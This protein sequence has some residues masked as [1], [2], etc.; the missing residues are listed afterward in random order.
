MDIIKNK[1][2]QASS[3]LKE[4]DIDCWIIYL[5]ESSMSPDPAMHMVIGHEVTWR[6]LFVYT[7]SGKAYALVG[8]FD[9]DN[10][11]RSGYFT[12]VMTYTE[13]QSQDIINLFDR[14]KPNKIAVNY[15]TDNVAAD[16]ISHGMFLILSKYL[17]GTPHEGK[18]ISSEPLISKLRS[19]KLPQEKELVKTAA[20]LAE[21]VWQSAMKDIQI[22]MSEIQIATIIEYY[23]LNSKNK[24][25]FPTIVNA[26]DK[27]RPGHSM[28]TSAKIEQGD[29]LHV[30]FGIRHE[31]FCS[32][33]QRLLYFKKDGED[34]PPEDLTVAFNIVRD[35]I[36]ETGKISKQGVQGHEIDALA[37]KMLK[38][39]GYPEYQHALGHQLGRD[40]HDGGAI[41]GPKWERYGI[42]PTIPLELNNIFTLELEIMLPDIGCVGLEEDMIVTENGAEYLCPR[43][44]ELYIK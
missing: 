22:G 21:D 44:M 34:N 23:I 30:D 27:T 1:I 11:V 40:V 42:T 29:L 24:P 5:R 15:S 39:N 35:I 28:P 13:N 10:F 36:T 17:K 4:L 26:G 19:R 33:L 2:E 6:S 37:R 18:L 9:Q 16:G 3:I 38:D 20:E 32:D 31:G 12:E 14:I 7:K 25:S 41:I 43:Q 8:Q